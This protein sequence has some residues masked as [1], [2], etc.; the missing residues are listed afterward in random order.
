MQPLVTRHIPDTMASM[1]DRQ[2]TNHAQPSSARDLPLDLAID[3]FL[4]H[5]VGSRSPRNTVQSYRYDLGLLDRAN[6]GVAVSGLKPADIARFLAGADAPATRKR[7]LTSLRRFFAWLGTA[8][9]IDNDP[10]EGIRHQRLAVPPPDVLTGME[11]QA[12]L[13]AA[14]LD[15]PWALLAIRLML[16]CG[17]RRSELLALSPSDIKTGSNPCVVVESFEPAR[18]WLRR[19]VP[20]PDDHEDALER[21]RER[22]LPGPTLFPVGPQ[23]VNG[24]LDRVRK[25]ANVT[26]RVTPRMLRDT[27]AHS[28]ARNGVEADEMLRL[29][30]MADE[31]RNRQTIAAIIRHVR[32]P[33]TASPIS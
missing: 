8:S 11:S 28:L 3:R 4:V 30:G 13:P 10:L 16:H 32:E 29:L 19:V 15:E 25:R 1:A 18:P 14:A 22:R 2:A 7:R 9:E 17:L 26:R 21:W 27:W 24:M 5:L 12:L 6:P 31:Y 23:A 33:G 20:A